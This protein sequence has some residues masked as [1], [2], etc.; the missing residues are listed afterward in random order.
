MRLVRASR[1]Y[2]PREAE[3]WVCSWISTHGE[4]GMGFVTHV[5]TFRVRI[6]RGGVLLGSLSEQA[7]PH[8]LGCSIPTAMAVNGMDGRAVR[9][10]R[11]SYSSF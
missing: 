3:L 2:M 4:W 9:K 10:L 8:A 5:L 7:A 11:S 6:S 1:P